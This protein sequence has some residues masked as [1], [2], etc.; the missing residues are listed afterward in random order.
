MTTKAQR[1]TM[2]KATT[3]TAKSPS[4]KTRPVAKTTTLPT[5]KRRTAKSGAAIRLVT[6]PSPSP[7][8]SPYE[9]AC[10]WHDLEQKRIAFPVFGDATE[11][12]ALV[13]EQAYI[14]A[15]LGSLPTEATM[16]A[17]FRVEV[18]WRHGTR[19][20]LNHLVRVFAAQRDFVCLGNGSCLSPDAPRG[21]AKVVSVP[22]S[23][24]FA[25]RVLRPHIDHALGEL[26][27][28]LAPHLAADEA[29]IL[30]LPEPVRVLAAPLYPHRWPWQEPVRAQAVAG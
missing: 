24:F 2:A 14:A 28:L 20:N 18:R 27:Q 8:P 5:T 7:T 23:G 13:S 30:V 6:R 10:R 26:S 22:Q 1:M 16:N 3:K 19:V 12:A 29:E 11:C 25:F 4:R 15:R 9:L 17:P 21:S